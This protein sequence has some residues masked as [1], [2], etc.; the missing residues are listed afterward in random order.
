MQDVSL[1]I[2]SESPPC[3]LCGSSEVIP[4]RTTRDWITGQPGTFR[5]V[6]CGACGLLFL[7]PRPDRTSI[8]RFYPD[9]N[10]HAFREPGG[11]KG[12]VVRRLRRREARTVLRGGP[13]GARVLEVGCGT[14]DLLVALRDRGAQVQ[15]IEP[16]A[17][18][19]QVAIGR[20]L[21][22][23]VGTLESVPLQP[24]KFDVILMRYALEHV[25]SPRQAL[26]TIYT[27]LRSGGRCI[28][29]VPNVESWDA[30]L[31]GTVWRGLDA[32]RH[33]Y[34]FT[35]QTMRSLLEAC[36]LSPVAMQYSGVPNDWAGSLHSALKRAGLPDAIGKFFGLEN[37]A[38]LAAWTPVSLAAALCCRAGRM[39]V[40]AVKDRPHSPG[41]LPSR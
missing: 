9:L 15:G 31:F 16:N 30:A 3:D 7:S 40:T 5:F 34:L 17:A 24:E 1:A 38:M 25:H 23:Q 6:R 4:W 39:R 20:G 22:V 41:A 19:A 35:P 27:A 8:A 37:P 12:Q 21:A 2:A 11:L 18:A 28:L 10:Y 36:D 13:E 26:R 32:P 29:W 33:L 14:G